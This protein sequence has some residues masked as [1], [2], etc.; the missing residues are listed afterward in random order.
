MFCVQVFLYLSNRGVDH[1][2]LDSVLGSFL[3]FD[4]RLIVDASFRTT[5]PLIFGAGPLTRF[6]CRFFSDCP[7][8]NVNSKEVGQKLA[9]AILA[10]LDPPQEAH[11]QPDR[12]VP[13][14][15]RPKVQ[16]VFQAVVLFWFCSFCQPST[17]SSLF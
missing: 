5:D 8:A 11:N 1:D 15:N 12:L 16:G 10:L 14:Y 13:L 7:H 3:A 9:V 6:S 17:F 2:V 4:S